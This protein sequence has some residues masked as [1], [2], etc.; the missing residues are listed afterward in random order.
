MREFSEFVPN[1][2]LRHIYWNVVFPIVY[3][4]ANS[5]EIGQNRTR[6]G[7]R[8]DRHMV[9]QCLSQIGKGNEV[10][11]FPSRSSFLQKL[12]WTHYDSEVERD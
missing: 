4:E 11:T 1:H 3:H 10:R 2:V 5:H 7:L 8:L 12:C 9:R 6:P